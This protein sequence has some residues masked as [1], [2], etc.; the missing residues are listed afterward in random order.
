MNKLY[1][2][3]TVDCFLEVTIFGAYDDEQEA[4]TEALRL[5]DS[6]TEIH[7]KKTNY[8]KSENKNAL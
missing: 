2:V 8:L 4:M 6:I 5:S 7:V 3:Y 1:I